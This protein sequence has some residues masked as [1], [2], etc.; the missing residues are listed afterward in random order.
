MKIIFN[1]K[2]NPQMWTTPTPEDHDLTNLNQ[3]KAFQAKWF[4][5]YLKFILYVYLCK[6]LTPPPAIVAQPYPR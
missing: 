3:V 2:C 4:L 6:N 5:R 1:V